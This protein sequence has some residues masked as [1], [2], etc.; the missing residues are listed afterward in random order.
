M[1]HVPVLALLESRLDT[2]TARALVC[3]VAHD[4]VFEA[5]EDT[6]LLN[7]LD[8]DSS[9]TRNALET[10]VVEKHLAPEEALGTG[11]RILALLA[12]LC[13]TTATSVLGPAEP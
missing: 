11:L 9:T 12:G 8:E 2:A 3:A 6:D 1:H 13:R 5:P 10:L 4:Y 7:R